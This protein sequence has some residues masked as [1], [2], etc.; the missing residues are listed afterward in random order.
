MLG[1]LECF[2]SSAESGSFSAAGRKL[3]IS[4][5]AVGKN[6]TEQFHLQ[7]LATRFDAR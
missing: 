4:A 5:A 2:V 3:G 7:K 1:H 6:V